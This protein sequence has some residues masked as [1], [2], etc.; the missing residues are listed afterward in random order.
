M[1]L[2]LDHVVLRVGDLDAAVAEF[3][4][5]G[6]TVTPGGQHPAWG[7]ENALVV[8]ADGTYLELI[9]F[10][11]A[12]GES[13]GQCMARLAAEGRDLQYQ[14]MAS[15]GAVA[16]G[17]ID[18]AVRPAADG[19]PLGAE[20]QRLSAVGLEVFGP[21]AGS[22]R[23]PDGQRVA[24]E[25]ATTASLA[26]PFFCAD[27]TPP[28]L[29]MPGGAARRHANGALGIAGVHVLSRAAAEDSRALRSLFERAPEPVGGEGGAVFEVPG[30]RLTL[31][32][33]VDGEAHA[34][35]AERGSAPR[36][37]D[38]RTAGAVS[39]SDLRHYGIFARV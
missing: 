34:A 37:L 24:W 3:S 32:A 2:T 5:A 29:R 38:I 28:A 17:L 16:A 31:A 36:R 4:R 18:Y 33:P 30:W 15:W 10:P 12:P 23:R 21:V 35:L 14:R 7:S 20:L 13:R 26:L 25:M 11:P 9:A 22:R 19:S 8:F 27:V 6:F 1:A 39:L